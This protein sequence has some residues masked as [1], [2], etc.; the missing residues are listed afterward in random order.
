MKFELLSVELPWLLSLLPLALLPLLNSGISN[1]QI[2]SHFFLPE[3]KAGQWLARLWRLLACVTI[4]A[5]LVSLAGPGLSETAQERTGRGAEISILMDRSS[6]MDTMIRRNAPE[7]GRA[8][9]AS[10]NKNEVVRHALLELISERPQNRYALTL[11]NAAA[12]RVAPFTDDVEIV[13]SGLE[14]SG[15][16]RGPSETPSDYA[17]I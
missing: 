8:A 11:F 3:D 2:A 9:Q 13:K 6:S 16:G 12:L 1:L 4:A 14:A 15:I 7:P 17:C 10:Q 5:L